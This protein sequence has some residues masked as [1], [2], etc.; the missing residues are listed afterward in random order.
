VAVI[1]P[2]IISIYSALKSYFVPSLFLFF[3]QVDL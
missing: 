1:C 3:Y 2:R